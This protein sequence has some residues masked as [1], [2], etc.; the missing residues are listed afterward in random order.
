ME[1]FKIPVT[2]EMGGFI[3]IHAETAELALEQAKSKFHEL[4]L[5]AD[6]FYRD[7][8]FVIEEEYFLEGL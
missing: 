7:D 8:S 3:E 2:Y 5:P 1:T 6:A 4:P